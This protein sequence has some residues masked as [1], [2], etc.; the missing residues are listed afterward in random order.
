MLAPSASSM[1]PSLHDRIVLRPTKT[2]LPMRMPRLVV[3]F[4]SSRQLSSM[5]TLLADV[6]LVRM[7]QHDVLA[8]D[9]V[10]AA[11]AEQRRIE[12]LAQ[13]QPERAGTRL[14]EHDD[15]LVLQQRAETRPPDHELGVF[16]PARLAGR[17]QLV[18]RLADP[19]RAA[20]YV[21]AS[22]ASRYQSSVAPD[23]V[24]QADS[25]RVADLRRARA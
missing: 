1:S 3:P 14:R 13:R 21:R 15:Q 12:R 9:D 2:P 10:A 4:A 16:L 6:D 7:A 8:E 22:H 23:A 5:T 18:L 25:R 24:A 17:E 20:G 11:G 19:R